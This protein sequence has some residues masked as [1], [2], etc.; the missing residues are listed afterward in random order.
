[1][2]KFAMINLTYA[3]DTKKMTAFNKKFTAASLKKLLKCEEV[4]DLKVADYDVSTLKSVTE[5]DE[6][7]FDNLVNEL[8]D[9]NIS[10][11]TK[12]SYC[13]SNSQK[14][15][16]FSCDATRSSFAFEKLKDNVTI[17]L[18][19]LD[20]EDDVDTF[21][22]N[23]ENIKSNNESIEELNDAKETLQNL[24]NYENQFSLNLIQSD[25]EDEI[26]RMSEELESE[27]EDASEQI[28][29]KLM[30]S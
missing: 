27:V 20:D 10:S 12:N 30:W 14:Y 21:I 26:E 3:H 6:E 15:F 23:I 24:E 17:T 19:E 28:R 2:T 16:A 13:G 7:K 29:D 22:E 9:F 11:L 25:A 5:I 8:S 1:M 18:F 4:L